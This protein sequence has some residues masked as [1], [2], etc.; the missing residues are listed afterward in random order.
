AAR[1]FSR[2][3]RIRRSKRVSSRRSDNERS[4]RVQALLGVTALGALIFA[5]INFLKSCRAGDANAV[6]TQLIVWTAGVV[7]VWFAFQTQWGVSIFNQLLGTP[8]T[9]MST[10]DLVWVG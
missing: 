6:F 2:Q 4:K 8:V 7:G 10:A 5:F 1:I 3:P 9:H